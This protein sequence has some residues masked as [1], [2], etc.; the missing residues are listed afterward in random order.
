MFCYPYTHILCKIVDDLAG[1]SGVS[2]EKCFLRIVL[3]G[4]MVVDAE[5]HLSAVYRLVSSHKFFIGYINCDNGLRLEIL[6][7]AARSHEIIALREGIAA[8]YSASNAEFCENVLKAEACADTVTV[9]RLMCDYDSVSAI[10]EKAFCLAESNKHITPLSYLSDLF[11]DQSRSL[12][13]LLISA[14]RSMEL[15]AMKLSSGDF[16]IS[17]R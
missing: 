16:L 15:S 14:L 12:S 3:V 4:D 9:R 11:S 2:A 7:C 5:L 6:T 8:N 13:F 1:S 10:A 17:R